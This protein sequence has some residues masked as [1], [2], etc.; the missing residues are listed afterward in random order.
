MSLAANLIPYASLLQRMLPRESLPLIRRMAGNLLASIQKKRQKMVEKNL[1]MIGIPPTKKLIRETIR[2]WTHCI[3]HQL[4]SL[5]MRSNELSG[6]VNDRGGIDRI[7]ESLKEGKGAI[8]VTAH[9]GNYELAGS[10]LAV[11]GFPVHAVVEEIAGGHTRAVNRIRRRFG[12]GVI[13]YSDIPGMLEVLRKGR[14]LVL[15]GD[16]DLGGNGLEV[17]FGNSTR[18]VPA[19]PALLSLRT[20]SPIQTGYFVLDKARKGYNFFM[21]RHISSASKGSLCERSQ[22]LTRHVTDQLVAMIKSYPDQWFCFHP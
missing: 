5:Q 3:S 15:L 20:G 14:I 17:D 12:M 16:R 11:R 1:L 6:M 9:L 7:S 13:G 21:N 4:Q 22:N 2:N 8:L 19:G 10:Y 18:R